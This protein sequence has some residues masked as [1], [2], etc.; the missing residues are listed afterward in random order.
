VAQDNKL[1]IVTMDQDFNRAREV[2]EIVPIP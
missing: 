1:A 2:L